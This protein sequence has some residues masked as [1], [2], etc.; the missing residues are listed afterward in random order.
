MHVS[1][2]RVRIHSPSVSVC[3]FSSNTGLANPREWSQDR[4]TPHARFTMGVGAPHTSASSMHN[5]HDDVVVVHDTPDTGA[6]PS[7][8]TVS[9]SSTASRQHHAPPGLSGRDDGDLDAAYE[10]YVLSRG[11]TRTIRKILIANNGC[12]SYTRRARRARVQSA[13]VVVDILETRA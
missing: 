1:L 12:T 11:G 5:T 3:I 8:S 4:I 2:T 6:P 13:D 7:S 9:S 10:S